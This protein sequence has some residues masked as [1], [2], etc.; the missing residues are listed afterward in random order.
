MKFKPT[1]LCAAAS[2]GMLASCGSGA[3]AVTYVGQGSYVEAEYAGD[4]VDVVAGSLTLSGSN[5]TLIQSTL[6]TQVGGNIVHSVTYS[7]EGTFTKGAEDK[8]NNTFTVTL[9]A[10]TKGYK[11]I[12]GSKTTSEDDASVLT[13]HI[14]KGGVYT[15]HT[16][17]M[18]FDLITVQGI[19]F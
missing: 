19:L 13:A 6:C 9:A 7:V 4:V 12:N 18:K 10:A 17:T 16:D 5:Y 11:V 3:Q 8:E 1:L 14:G 2:L 15:I